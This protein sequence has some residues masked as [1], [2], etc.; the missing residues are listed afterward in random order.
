MPKSKDKDTGW[1]ARANGRLRPD[2][3]DQYGRTN[4]VS[5]TWGDTQGTALANIAATG[6]AGPFHA[7]KV[8]K[9]IQK[10]GRVMPSPLP[11]NPEHC[12]LFGVYEKDFY[13]LFS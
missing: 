11:N 6:L 8:E 9:I 1:V 13:N 5:V 2:E 12:N 7:A 3:I 4:D 10:Q